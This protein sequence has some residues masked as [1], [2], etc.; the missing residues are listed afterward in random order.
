MRTN[1]M[2]KSKSCNQLT[3]GLFNYRGI[4]F[5]HNI[6]DLRIY[7]KR[8]FYVLKHGYFPQA[9][10]ETYCYF[11]D[12]MKKILRE[13]R[14]N[15]HGTGWVLDENIDETLDIDEQWKKSS[16]RYDKDL[17]E[18][19]SL[20]EDMDQDSEKYKNLN[21]L[22]VMKKSNAAKEKF[23]VLFSKYFYHLWD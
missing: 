14:Y 1:N 21:F 12:S 22:D 17:D 19:L 6:K 16:E 13:Y 2:R 18:M 7:F 11:I 23:F 20:L 8:I 5:W 4:Y 15:R 9:N 3:W 10:W